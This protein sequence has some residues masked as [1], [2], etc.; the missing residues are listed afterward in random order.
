MQV[1]GQK[2][3]C[4]AH[5]PHVMYKDQRMCIRWDGSFSDRFRVSNGV[6]H[7]GVLSLIMLIIYVDDL[8]EDLSKLGIGCYWDSL[9]AGSAC[10]HWKKCS[11]KITY[12]VVTPVSM[13]SCCKLSIIQ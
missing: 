4:S 3:S 12:G 7:G 2:F 10:M 11:V 6:Q 13:N 5:P 9:F 1:V 8:L